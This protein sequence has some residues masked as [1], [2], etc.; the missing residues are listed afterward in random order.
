MDIL[1]GSLRVPLWLSA[2][3]AYLF[4]L[5]ML[6]TFS[7]TSSIFAATSASVN[8]TTVYEGDPIILT[9]ESSQN[10]AQ[11][12][13]SP[14]EMDFGILSTNTSSQINIINGQRS[15]KKSWTVQLIAKH[16]GQ[17]NIPALQVGGEATL[18]IQ[19]NVTTL[20]PEVKAETGKHITIEAFIGVPKS[21]SNSNKQKET[22]VQQQI[23]YTIKLIYDSSMLSGE[24][25]EPNVENA[26]IEK[27]GRDKR[28]KI[29]K[30]GQRFTVIEKHYVISPEK[31]GRLRI[32]A[33]T[34]KG[35]IALSGGDSKKLRRRMDDTDMLNRFFND[36]N[37]ISND[38][39]FSDPFGNDFFRSRR[40]R[41]GP[42]KPFSASTEAIEVNVLPVPSEFTGSNWLPAEALS[43]KDSWA[44]NPP[45]LKVG[46][47]VVRTLTLQAKGLAGSQ[48]PEMKIQKPDDMKMYP[49]PARVETKTDGQTVYGIQQIDLTYIPSKSGDIIIPEITLD[50]WNIRTKKQ[51]TLVLP[52][53]TLQVA[54]GAVPEETST[55]KVEEK[56]NEQVSQISKPDQN[57]EDN[58]SSKQS[59]KTPWFSY[60]LATTLILFLAVIAYLIYRRNKSKITLSKNKLKPVANIP[61]LKKATLEA[62]EKNDKHLAAK[63]LLS[64]I[65]AQWND[66]SISNLGVLINQMANE[67]TA[68][69]ALEKSLYAPESSEWDGKD[70]ANLITSGI[71]RKLIKETVNKEFLKPL[72][73]N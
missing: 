20:P 71:E 70:L 61:A 55:T 37:G 5:L 35:K 40:S 36:L 68:I 11:P 14:L 28:Y 32:P 7:P 67:S 25:S 43:L 45:N 51:Q 50:W 49:E 2:L 64:L 66:S 57:S 27:L 34:V 4:I 53:W 10:A 56:A 31:S 48:I 59:N 41:I 13:L 73:P 58:E 65:Q 63:N 23:P 3:K 22:Y 44:K 17:Y 52:K 21:V 69:K 30:V 62:C 8:Q 60:L 72:Y 16:L 15:F 6:V 12:N 9:I 18:P 47:P 33:I 46:E 42:S 54:Q 24:I 39:F 1:C 29:K 19:L 26:V 38:P